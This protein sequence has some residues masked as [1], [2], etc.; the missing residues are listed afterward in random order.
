MAVLIIPLLF[1][2]IFSHPPQV[3]FGIFL[4]YALSGPVLALYGLSRRGLPRR[5]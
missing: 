4:L 3:L 5:R 1:V 2:L